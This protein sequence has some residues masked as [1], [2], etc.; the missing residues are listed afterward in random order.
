M[1]AKQ[2]EKLI[3]QTSIIG[4]VVNLIMVVFKMIVGALSHSIAIIL[5]A[6]NN[7]SDALSSIITI[8]GAKVAGKQPDKKHPMG[9]G[10]IEYLSTLIVSGV[11]LYAGITS[12][13]EAVKSIIHPEKA[14]YSTASIV[15]IAVAVVAKLLLGLFVKKR[16]KSIGSVALEASGTEALFDAILSVT[17]LVSIAVYMITDLS[18]EA[19]VALILSIFILKAGIEMMMDTINDILGR[20]ID[21]DVA[22]QIKQI[23]VSEPEVRGA[24][25]LFTNNYGPSKN[26]SSVHIELP[27]TMT[28]SEVDALSRRIQ[29]KVY[30]ETGIILSAIGVYS[31][32]TGDN[33]LREMEDRLRTAVV[34]HEGVLQ[35]HG[36]YVEEQA[37]EVRF[38]VVINF[39]VDADE[40][41]TILK[42]E[43][44]EIYPGYTALIQKD[45]D[46]SD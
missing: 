6:V 18:I 4:I 10:R 2:R 40:M 39:K 29:K 31:Y 27:D 45:I 20:R 23:I 7:L 34:A 32:N 44:E 19:Y 5:D 13:V 16:G 14:E 11:V 22:K 46:V 21:P 25:D 28:V 43:V 1:E 8:I 30:N 24:Y 26:Y 9:Y 38:D 12:A 41:L 42:S 37:K 33:I 3:V 35:M 36:F 15:I 17:V